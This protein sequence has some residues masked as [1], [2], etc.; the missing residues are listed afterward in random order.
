MDCSL[1]KA[2]CGQVV[3]SVVPLVACGL[4]VPLVVLIVHSSFG[5]Y[6]ARDVLVSF[7]R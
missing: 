2:S 4:V 7:D 3:P 1:I 5:V 6:M